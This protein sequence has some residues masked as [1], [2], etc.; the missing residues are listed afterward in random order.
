[1]G[2]SGLLTDER[3]AAPAPAPAPAAAPA[4]TPVAA[5]F[6]CSERLMGL[7]VDVVG[8]SN[9]PDSEVAMAG[10]GVPGVALAA[11]VCSDISARVGDLNP[12]A[13]NADTF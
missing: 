5:D 1:M 3:P 13:R 6:F 7:I 12:S 2:A 4:A 11:L 8:A 9:M 10:A